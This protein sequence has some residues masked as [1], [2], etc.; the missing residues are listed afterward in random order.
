METLKLGNVES[1]M[2][3]VEVL[4]CHHALAFSFC[5]VGKC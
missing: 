3:D 5:A 2:K 4:W 1:C